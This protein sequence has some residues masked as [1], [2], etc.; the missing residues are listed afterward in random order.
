MDF[1]ISKRIGNGMEYIK[2]FKFVPSEYEYEYSHLMTNFKK[3]I[4]ERSGKI[5]MISSL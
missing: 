5:W 1:R 4:H 2:K 3:E